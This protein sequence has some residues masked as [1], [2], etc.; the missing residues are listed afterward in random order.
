MIGLAICLC[1]ATIGLFVL[2]G[3]LIYESL[4]K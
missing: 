3:V 4:H 2:A 1:A